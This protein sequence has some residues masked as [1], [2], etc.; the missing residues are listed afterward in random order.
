MKGAAGLG[1][2]FPPRDAG[3]VGQGWGWG[4]AGSTSETPEEVTGRGS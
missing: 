1:T 3:P 4:A 2:S